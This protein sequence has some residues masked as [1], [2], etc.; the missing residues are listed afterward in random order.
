MGPGVPGGNCVSPEAAI[1]M[2]SANVQRVRES[3]GESWSRL[4]EGESNLHG[5]GKGFRERVRAAGV[6][7]GGGSAGAFEAFGVFGIF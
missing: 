2:S 4:Q 3:D 7:G 5:D 1:R 6:S